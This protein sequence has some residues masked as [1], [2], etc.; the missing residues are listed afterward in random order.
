MS[1]RLNLWAYLFL[2]SATGLLANNRYGLPIVPKPQQ[3]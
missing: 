1:V 2:F 3:E